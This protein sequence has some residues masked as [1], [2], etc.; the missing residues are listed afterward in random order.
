MFPG[1]TEDTAQLCWPVPLSSAGSDAA[2]G[3]QHKRAP[4]P[5][6]TR[7]ISGLSQCPPAS[8]AHPARPG[9]HPRCLP[10]PSPECCIQW[11]RKTPTPGMAAD[12]LKTTATF[13]ADPTPGMAADRLKATATFQ[14]GNLE[15]QSKALSSLLPGGSQKT[16][17]LVIPKGLRA[18]GLA[19]GTSG[20][21]WGSCQQPGGRAGPRSGGAGCPEVRSG[22]EAKGTAT[23]IRL[24]SP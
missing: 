22:L 20:V 8:L 19:P 6:T 15:Q 7:H 4:A 12:Q 5:D 18:P 23:S 21:G 17:P 16:P 24:A 11:S 9:G 1:K 10:N 14:A 13:Q 2:A 3:S